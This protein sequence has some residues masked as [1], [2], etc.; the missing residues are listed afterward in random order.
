MKVGD[1]FIGRDTP[2]TIHKIDGKQGIVLSRPNRYGQY[3]VFIIGRVL[4]LLKEHMEVVN[5]SG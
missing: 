3:K 1:L 4:W 5:E 2:I